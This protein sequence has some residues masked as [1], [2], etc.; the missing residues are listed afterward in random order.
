MGEVSLVRAQY[1]QIQENSRKVLSRLNQE[2]RNERTRGV[3]ELEKKA[4]ETQRLTTELEFLKNEAIEAKRR[5]ANLESIRRTDERRASQLPEAPQGAKNPQAPTRETNAPPGWS[6]A[7]AQRPQPTANKRSR[8]GLVST[9][10]DGFADNE[11]IAGG[12]QHHLVTRVGAKRKRDVVT[13]GLPALPL[14]QPIALAQDEALP[15]GEA[16]PILF[17]EVSEDPL[18]R[19]DFRLLEKLSLQDDRE[20]LY[21]AL[22]RHTVPDEGKT[23]LAQL[24][25]FRL[26]N[27]QDDIAFELMDSMTSLRVSAAQGEFSS[28][29]FRLL[30]SMLES[31][32]T[33][34]YVS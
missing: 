24:S 33:H 16:Q 28:G 2:R 29:I 27:S 32:L 5:I 22:K 1:A 30:T 8:T 15:Q 6:Q 9:V 12:S 20:Y 4:K 7:R 14:S 19:I 31:C 11:L 34:T 13:S 17:Q 10:S 3:Q 21:E 18:A 23:V 25:K 26:P